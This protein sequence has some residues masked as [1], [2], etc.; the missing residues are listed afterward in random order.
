MYK[1]LV[2]TAPDSVIITNSIGKIEQANEQTMKLFCVR[3]QEDIIGKPIHELVANKDRL[4]LQ[5][6]III[7]FNQ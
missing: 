2:S 7:E 5:K 4:K 3:S 1:L 6:F